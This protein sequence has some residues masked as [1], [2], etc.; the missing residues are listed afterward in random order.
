MKQL[1]HIFCTTNNSKGFMTGIPQWYTVVYLISPKSDQATIRKSICVK[2]GPCHSTDSFSAQDYNR[3]QGR[4]GKH[5]LEIKSKP[6]FCCAVLCMIRE[7]QLP[8]LAVSGGRLSPILALYFHWN[9][10]KSHI[11]P[12]S[13]RA[14]ISPVS[15]TAAI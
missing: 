7:R 11:T 8:S 12:F 15:C 2:A 3:M 5:Q 4:L 9:G 13:F 6:S 14:K 10:H 1:R